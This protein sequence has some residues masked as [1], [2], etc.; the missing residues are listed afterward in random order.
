M[1]NMLTVYF[2]RWDGAHCRRRVG[3]RKP[4]HADNR[5][6]GEYDIHGASIESGGLE[7]GGSIRVRVKRR[8]EDI[9]LPVIIAGHQIVG[10]AIEGYGAAVP[11]EDRVA[12][13][14]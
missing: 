12:G 14:I 4:E 9:R 3:L 8:R 7:H 2:G 1:G 5:W 6:R 11:A 13:E 10:Q